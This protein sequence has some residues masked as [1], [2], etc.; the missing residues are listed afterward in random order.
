M[1]AEH[2][3]A[4]GAADFDARVIEESRTRAVLVDF[5]AAWCGPCRS[6]APVLEQLADGLEGRLAIAKVDS[7]AEPELA[8]RYG[9]RSLPT[10]ILFKDGAPVAQT[11]GAQ[12]LSA[13]HA[14]VA[15]HLDRP[16]DRLRRHAQDIAASE[17]A[18]AI[19]LLEQALAEDPENFR[20]HAELAAL[21]IDAGRL[22]RAAEVLDALPALAADEASQRQEARLRFAR[23]AGA[24]PA[25]EALAAALANEPPSTEARYYAA[26]RKLAAGDLGGGLED[27]IAIVRSDRKY[28][29]DAARRTVLDVFAL[30][31][32]SDPR[33]R[34]YRTALARALN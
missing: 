19:T 11:M 23:L 22:E 18:A 28:G 3:Y 10:L 31:D 26:V 34:E 2:V 9:V 5:W 6:L 14:F 15:P 1:A 27:L 8:G 24:G 17:P 13:L 16:T 32:A 7:D 25:P 33:L 20:I 30:M 29:D 21:L 4:V 12:P